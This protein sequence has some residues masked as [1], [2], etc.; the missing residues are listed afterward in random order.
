[1]EV[2]CCPPKP[3]L[4]VR[5]NR[6][7]CVPPVLSQVTEIHVRSEIGERQRSYDKL[8]VLL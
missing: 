6:W 7:L 1:M 8:G 5:L 4:R 2:D 3:A